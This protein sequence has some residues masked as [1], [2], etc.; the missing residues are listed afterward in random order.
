[1]VLIL[2]LND[3]IVCP[4]PPGYSSIDGSYHRYYKTGSSTANF[5]D[6]TL[7]CQADKATLVMARTEKEL[8]SMLNVYGNF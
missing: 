8:T 3:V 2:N 7:D 5:A 6:A 1:M 4:A